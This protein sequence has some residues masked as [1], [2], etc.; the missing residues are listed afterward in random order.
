MVFYSGSSDGYIRLW[1]CGSNFRKLEQ[2]Q[3]MPVAGFVND[4]A[5]SADGRALVAAVGQEHRLGRWTRLKEAKNCVVVVPL[6]T[7]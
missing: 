5:F 3:E 7:K 1:K 2:L 6:E 4:L